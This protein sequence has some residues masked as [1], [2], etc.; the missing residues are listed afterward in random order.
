M[1]DFH[2]KK[3]CL[4][5][6]IIV[7]VMLSS[8]QNRPQPKPGPPA[9]AIGVNVVLA[10][11]DLLEPFQKT[12]EELAKKEK[13]RLYWEQTE[14]G[15][16]Q[17]EKV[18]K[19]LERK[20]DSL[21]VQFAGAQ[22]A[23]DLAR[24]AAEKNVKLLALGFLPTGI[25]LDGFV[26]VDTR[27]VG[28]QQGSFLAGALKEL[29]R[30]RVLI[31]QT[32]PDN[33][34]EQEILEGNIKSLED[35]PQIQVLVHSFP[36]EDV[37]ASLNRLWSQLGAV[38]GIITH[39]P[40][41][42]KELLS[43]LVSQEFTPITVGLGATRELVEMIAAGDHD[44]EVDLVPEVMASYAFQGALS[45]AQNGQW[46]F[47]KQVVSGPYDV[48][49]KYVPTRLIT[50]DN[51]YLLE[52]RFGKIKS[53]KA[54]PPQAGEEGSPT[55]GESEEKSNSGSQGESEGEGSGQGK[56]GQ[57]AS[58]IKVKIKGGKTMEMEVPGEIES[59]Q[60]EGGLPGEKT[61][62]ESQER[63]GS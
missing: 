11:K 62:D 25:P 13:V 31:L 44:G 40:S 28:E 54:E 26:G 8:C 9:A 22:E 48:P 29:P 61:G 37:A 34:A 27:R 63:P 39:D 36:V 30:S 59:I 43:S 5:G 56:Q 1:L 47:E 3:W 7:A 50:R 41:S 45:L 10:E 23:S 17:Q 53:Q 38:E 55:K 32:D 42:T 35:Y 33:P 20:V 6:L 14:E 49:V 51:L 21:L 60:I 15:T 24:Q 57:S 18:R 4:I 19:L 52:N 16:D 58:K 12:M 2:R 46:D